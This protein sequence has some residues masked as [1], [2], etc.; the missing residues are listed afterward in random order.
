MTKLIK[1]TKKYF[2]KYPCFNG[3]VHLL[4]GI[5]IGFLLTYPVVGSH[6]VRWGVTFIVLGVLGH[7]WAVIKK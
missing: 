3:S 2:G 6:P 1:K 5:G 7:V 4:I